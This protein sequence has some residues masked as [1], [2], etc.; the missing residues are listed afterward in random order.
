MSLSQ[1]TANRYLYLS[2]FLSTWNSRAFEFGAVLFVS[3][4]FPGS[5]LPTSVYA[6]ARPLSAI[7]FASVVGTY[8]DTHDRLH[9][10]RLSICR[11]PFLVQL[12]LVRSFTFSS[13]PAFG[14]CTFLCRHLPPTS[15]KDMVS[16]RKVVM[17]RRDISPCL[18]GKAVCCDES[19][20][21][22][23]WLGM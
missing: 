19:R 12:Q 2:H 11:R 13:I 1:S 4:A 7:L 10:V 8:I 17:F 14:S 9:V 20:L 22:W 18:C 23:A 5:L 16:C 3:T 6:L 15:W 21:N